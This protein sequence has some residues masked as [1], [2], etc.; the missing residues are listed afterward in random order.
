ML[1]V[2]QWH[3]YF[4]ISVLVGKL[5]MEK[6]KAT[7]INRSIVMFA[8]DRVFSTRTYWFTKRHHVNQKCIDIVRCFIGFLSEYCASKSNCYFQHTS[9]LRELQ[10]ISHM[11]VSQNALHTDWT[12]C[13]EVIVW[14]FAVKYM[15]KI[16]YRILMAERILLTSTRRGILMQLVSSFWDVLG[17]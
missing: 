16:Y 10:R 15:Y 6:G 9:P 12:W 7:K 4:Y 5:K 11:F 3:I 13:T 14:V 2:Y 17:N 8:T 1:K